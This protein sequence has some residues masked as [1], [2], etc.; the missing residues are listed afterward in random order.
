MEV[1]EDGNIMDRIPILLQRDLEY[2]QQNQTVLSENVCRGVVGGRLDF[3]RSASFAAV[4][5]V[6]W[7]EEEFSIAFQHGS[8]MFVKTAEEVEDDGGVA[9]TSDP[10]KFVQTTIKSSDLLLEHLHMLVQE[11]L[12]HA[13]LPVLTA[14]LGAAALLKNSLFCYLQFVEDVGSKDSQAMLQAS[15]ISRSLGNR[16][17]ISRWYYN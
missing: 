9:K 1:I 13:D 16:I 12:D 3:P 7:L 15:A 11:A 14:T 8:G 4:K 6:I 5:I 10:D 2:Y 17:R